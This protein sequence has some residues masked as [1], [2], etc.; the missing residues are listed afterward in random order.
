MEFGERL[1]ALRLARGL[2]Q[3]ALAN[4]VNVSAVG[5]IVRQWEQGRAHPGFGNLRD[6]CLVLQTSADYLMGFTD[7]PSPRIGVQSV[8]LVQEL[9]G[10]A[11]LAAAAEN[12]A[13]DT[14][15]RATRSSR[16]PRNPPE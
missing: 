11:S 10:I 8:R 15:R 9:R 13:A 6:L 1:R 5:G 2:T 16:P 4:A 3:E 7:D 14:T 12:E